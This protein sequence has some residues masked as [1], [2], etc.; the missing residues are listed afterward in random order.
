MC[1]LVG[2][3]CVSQL[4]ALTYGFHDVK[5]LLFL[6]GFS[7]HDEIKFFFFFWQSS[8]SYKFNVKKK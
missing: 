2:F 5:N 3:T 8:G 7:V 4:V 6:C 1:L